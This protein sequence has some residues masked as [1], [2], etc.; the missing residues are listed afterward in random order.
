MEQAKNRPG[1]FKPGQSGNPNG[2]PPKGYSITAM[3]RE[4]FENEP[5]KKKALGEAIFKRAIAGDPTAIK[6]V[7]SY[8]DGAPM[9][10]VELTGKD[11]G[12]VQ[13]SL[14]VAFE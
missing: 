10:A 6:L 13:Q 2:R 14:T 7:W 12:P 11:G 4:M 9:Q 3:F 8:M 5:D 1:Q